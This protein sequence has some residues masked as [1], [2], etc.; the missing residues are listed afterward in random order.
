[1]TDKEYEGDV[2]SNNLRAA[3]YRPAEGEDR[4]RTCAHVNLNNPFAPKDKC[5]KHNAYGISMDNVCDSYEAR[6]CNNCGCGRGS[7]DSRGH[8]YADFRCHPDFD[9]LLGY[10]PPAVPDV[11]PDTPGCERHV[12]VSRGY[13]ERME[14]YAAKDAESKRRERGRVPRDEDEYMEMRE[15]QRM[16]DDDNEMWRLERR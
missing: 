2:L 6:T 9:I 1:M 7:F 5:F 3:N 14:E 15:E 11:T 12:T 13:R 10:T 8:E 4:C 16:L